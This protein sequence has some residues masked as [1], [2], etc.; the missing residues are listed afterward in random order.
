[1]QQDAWRVTEARGFLMAVYP[2]ADW[3]ADPA[4]EAVLACAAALPD[5]VAAGTVR[6]A[7]AALPVPPLEGL[8]VPQAER[9]HQAYAFMANAY[10]WAP[11]LPPTR[12]LPVALAVPFAA[13]AEQVGRPPVLSYAGTQLCNFRLHDRT[14]GFAPENIVPIQMFQHSP[15][16]SWFWV[17]H[18]A[19]EAAGAAAVMAGPRACAAARAGD[20]AGLEAALTTILHG[21]EAVTALAHRIDEGC[22]PDSFFRTLRPFMFSP[23]EGIVFEGVARFGGQPQVFLGQTGAQSSLLPAICGSLGIRHGQSELTEYLDAVRAYMP[24]AHQAHLRSLDGSAV[25]GA[26]AADGRLRDLY[27][28]CV[29]AVVEF[30]RY[31]LSLAARYIAAHVPDPKGTGGTDFMHWLRQMTAETKAQRLGAQAS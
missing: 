16:E 25:R 8:S 27:D 24:P 6:P 20:A 12:T 21:L 18:I 13:V 7:V 1:M 26:A 23:P 28:A 11:G 15:D 14:A 30:R 10:C 5:H 9:L 2:P 31:H 17:I 29:A 4:T 22:S 19:I 3:A